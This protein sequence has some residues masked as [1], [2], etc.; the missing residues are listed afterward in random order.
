[1]QR[2]E[3]SDAINSTAHIAK[4]HGVKPCPDHITLALHLTAVVRAAPPDFAEV[5]NAGRPHCAT[6]L[7]VKGGHFAVRGASQPYY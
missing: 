2:H 1:M 6:L 3:T 5:A 4:Y 7:A